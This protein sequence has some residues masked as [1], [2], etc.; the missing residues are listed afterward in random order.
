MQERYAPFGYVPVEARGMPG[1]ELSLGEPRPLRVPD[2]G[3]QDRLEYDARVTLLPD[4]S[5]QVSLE[6][7]FAGKY[8]VRMRA[9]L[10]Q[11]PEG[12]LG[13]VIETRLLGQALPGAR[14]SD[15]EIIARDDLESPLVVRMSVSLGSFAERRPD[16]FVIAPPL[17]PRLSLLTGLATRQTPLLIREAMHQRVRFELQIDP[18]IRVLGLA[19]GQLEHGPHRV[20]ARDELRA[21]RLVIDREASIAAGRVAPDDYERFAAFTREAER[22]LLQPLVLRHSGR[23][24]QAP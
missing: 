19:N 23:G 20:R 4:G 2:A 16:G 11:V 5:A 18:A 24:S 21:G 15:Y 14:L 13:E 6:Q 8:A 7:L 10:E 9:G 17:M 1:F 3:D 22:L 12:R